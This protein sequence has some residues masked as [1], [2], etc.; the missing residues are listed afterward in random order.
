MNRVARAAD[1]QMNVTRDEVL[2]ELAAMSDAGADQTTTAGA[3]A[4][5][6]DAAEETVVT[7]LEVLQAAELARRRP[8]G[9]RITITGEELLA[10]DPKGPVIIN[11]GGGSP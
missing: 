9:V 1:S 4:A 2:D 10:L 8:D 7:H 5:A 3:L 6:L 11:P